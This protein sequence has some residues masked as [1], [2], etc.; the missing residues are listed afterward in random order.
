MI[1]YGTVRK[2]N[3]PLELRMCSFAKQYSFVHN[4]MHRK[5]QNE[6]GMALVKPRNYIFGIT[7]EP[8]IEQLIQNLILVLNNK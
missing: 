5:V 7:A 3:V 2:S 6:Q 1:H 8:S 4:M